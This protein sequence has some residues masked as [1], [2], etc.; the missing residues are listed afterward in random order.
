MNI[1]DIVN[2][3]SQ[4]RTKAD[5]I[6]VEDAI[7]I[8]RMAR[9]REA[10]RK[11]NVGDTVTFEHRSKNITGIVER[12]N[13]KSVSVSTESDGNWRVAPTLLELSNR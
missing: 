13:M 1:N 2:A 9:Q 4:L 6:R 12:V 10:G 8:A 11:F 5:I 3:V 7:K